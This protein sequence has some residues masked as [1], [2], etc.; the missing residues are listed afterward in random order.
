ML[1]KSLTELSA[2]LNTVLYLLL[3]SS[4]SEQDDPEAAIQIGIHPVMLQLKRSNTIMDTLLNTVLKSIDGMED[5]I[6]HLVLAAS[7]LAESN[8]CLGREDHVDFEQVTVHRDH[9]DGD[10]YD[11]RSFNESELPEEHVAKAQDDAFLSH[12]LE[13]ARFGLRQHEL[14]LENA[15]NLKR[16]KAP[17]F[18]DLDVETEGA[19]NTKGL[20]SVVN[21]IDQ[22]ARKLNKISHGLRFS[23]DHDYCNAEVAAGV[24]MMEA[25]LEGDKE[26]TEKSRKREVVHVRQNAEELDATDF[27]GQM[28]REAK[29]KMQ[30]KKELHMVAPKFPIFEG[31]VEGKGYEKHFDSV[32]LFIEMLTSCLVAR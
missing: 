26:V 16:R 24:R 15:R 23:E 12:V 30:L 21:A 11:Q 10:D 29:N 17:M 32:I 31:E 22:R 27:Y 8:E 13:D 9:A 4:V 5:Q 7:L 28:A 1:T 25:E 2:V 14:Q 19:R 18:L 20:S 6:R 3:K